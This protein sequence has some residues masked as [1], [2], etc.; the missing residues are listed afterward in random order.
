[1]K[2]WIAPNKYVN[3]IVLRD[4]HRHERQHE[5]RGLLQVYAITGET[6]AE[7]HRKLIEFRRKELLAAEKSLKHAKASLEKAES[8]KEPT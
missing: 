5:H 1:M 7:A 6:W 8:M 2:T 3:R 4:L